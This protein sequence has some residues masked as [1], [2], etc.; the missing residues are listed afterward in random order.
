MNI[1]DELIEYKN[2][3]IIVSVEE[4]RKMERAYIRQAVCMCECDKT[5]KER[6]AV[7]AGRSVKMIKQTG[8]GQGGRLC[9]TL[10]P[11]PLTT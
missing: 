9:I 5:Q 6:E 4:D 3:T 2:K 7:V 10:S 8:A 1:N 11:R